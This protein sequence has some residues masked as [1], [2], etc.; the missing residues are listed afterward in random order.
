MQIEDHHRA[1]TSAISDE[2]LLTRQEVEDTF[3]YPTKRFLEMAVIHGNGPPV[4]RFGR[5]VRYR[6][7]DLRAWIDAHRIAKDED[8]G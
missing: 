8:A 7:G 6:I 2:R 3:G 1:T 4:V 5:T